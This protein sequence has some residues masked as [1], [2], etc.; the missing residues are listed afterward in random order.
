[1]YC[2]FGIDNIFRLMGSV[3]FYMVLT[4]CLSNRGICSLREL[5]TSRGLQRERFISPVGE[6]GNSFW[7]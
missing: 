2:L 7:G 4:L 6:S 1:C 5:L 3:V